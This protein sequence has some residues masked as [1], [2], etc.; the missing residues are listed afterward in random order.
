MKHLVKALTKITAD[1]ELKINDHQKR[2]VVDEKGIGIYPMTPI[3]FLRLSTPNQAFI[4]DLMAASKDLDFYN[5]PEVQK[6]MYVHPFIEFDNNTGKV[7]AHEGRNR[8]AAVIKAGGS[9]FLV[10]LFPRPGHREH[11]KSELPTTLLGEFSNFKYDLDYD[12]MIEWVDFNFKNKKA[13]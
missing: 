1:K 2:T 9:V 12:K 10:A 8:A 13:G 3:D 11:V 6:G 7:T 4:K 5:S